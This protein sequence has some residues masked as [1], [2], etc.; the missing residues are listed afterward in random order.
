M[1]ISRFLRLA[2]C[3][4]TASILLQAQAPGPD[5][6]VVSVMGKEFT[7]AQIEQMRGSLPTQFKQT[8]EHMNNRAFLETFGYLQALA[9]LAEQ[10]GILDRE[11][12][13]SQFE[14]NRLN[15]LAQTYLSQINATLKIAEGEKEAYYE[16]NKQNF[17]QLEARVIAIAFDP[18]PEAVK[19]RE[20]VMERDAWEEAQKLVIELRQ[21][22]DFAELAREHS[23]DAATAESGG[24][25]GVVEAG[26]EGIPAEL[27]PKIFALGDG[28]FSEPVKNG[29]FYYIFQAKARTSKP[30]EEVQIQVLQGLQKQKLQERL[31]EIRTEVKVVA[32]D[33]AYLNAQP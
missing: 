20:P 27:L 14:F 22:A 10:D 1:K 29:Y 21:G 31:D 19:N 32:T 8:T 9:T 2:V 6:V 11:P 30:F 18:I 3:G 4:V 33:P 17:S 26:E 7:Q 25:L 24:N 23:D 16:A 28:Q 5:D 13:K 12:F 15:F